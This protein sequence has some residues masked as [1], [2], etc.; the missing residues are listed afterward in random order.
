MVLQAVVVSRVVNRKS[1]RKSFG[2]KG[3]DHLSQTILPL[4]EISLQETGIY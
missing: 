1:F 2:M 4:L 3:L